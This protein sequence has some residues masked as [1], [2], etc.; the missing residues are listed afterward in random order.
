M[1]GFPIKYAKGDKSKIEIVGKP[2]EVRKF[3]NPRTKVETEYVMEEA[4]TGDIGLVKA[5]KADKYGNLVFRQ[6]AQ[7]FN[8]DCAKA[9]RFT[10]AEVEELVENGE[11]EPSQIHVPGVYVK[12]IVHAPNTE[13]RIEKVKLAPIMESSGKEEETKTSAQIMRE[14]IVKRAAKELVSGMNVNLGI[15]MPTLIPSL[16]PPSINIMLQSENGYSN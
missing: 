7:N 1:G 13:K 14:R 12:A 10:I 9:A 8:P 3:T 4:I 11:L 5:W 16:L 15:G 6:T 2:L